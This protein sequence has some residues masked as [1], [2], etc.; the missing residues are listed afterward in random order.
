MS[1]LTAS[2][3]ITFARQVAPQLG[4][5]CRAL[6]DDRQDGAVRIVDD[7]GRALILYQEE[8][9]PERLFLTA[10]LPEAAEAAGFAVRPL[11]VAASSAAVHVAAHIRRRLL[12]S[13]AQVLAEY[14][15]RPAPPAG[16]Q[17]APADDITEPLTP[18]PGT[19]PRS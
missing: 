14:K 16:R 8:A 6:P 7:E 3:L 10:R 15:T 9:K 18:S 4:S 13:L 19:P 1:L 17:P 2:E 12:P 5:Q 11:T